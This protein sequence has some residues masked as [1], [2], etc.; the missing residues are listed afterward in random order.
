M[1]RTPARIVFLDIETA[2]SLG[3]V[4]GKWQQD[5]IDFKAN[6]YILSFAVKEMGSRE[7]KTYCLADYPNYE[8]DRENDA[9]L[10][11]EIWNVL[12]NAD[13]VIAHN[14]DK[15]DLPKINTRLLTHKQQPPSPYKTVDTL[16]IARKTF[17]FDSNKLDE[18]GRYLGVGR[19]MPHTGFHLWKSCME[20]DKKAW[21]KMKRYNAQDVILLEKI[22]FLMRPWA[23]THP[24]VNQGQ[25][26][27][28]PKCG[29]YKVQRR[30]FTYTMLRKKQRFQC[31][32]CTGW[33]EGS[34]V[35][36]D[37]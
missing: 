32:N 18:L 14:G 34:A 30:G 23:K 8:N 12:D 33:F 24:N 3:W 13:I 22:Y 20:G 31:T 28:C 15:F 9:E 5:V 4:W 10:L 6:W 11:K 25:L 37:K 36:V 29:S 7:V 1:E 26:Q 16:Q 27:A 17:K 19:K 21:A 35:K 2:P